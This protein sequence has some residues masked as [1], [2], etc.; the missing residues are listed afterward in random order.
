M[1]NLLEFAVGE[2][3]CYI[4][5]RIHDKDVKHVRCEIT[6]EMAKAM[7]TVVGK[8]IGNKDYICISV[9][10]DASYEKKRVFVYQHDFTY[11]LY[12]VWKD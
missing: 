2:R 4:S 10:E 12:I 5:D 9:N 7:A 1:K 3:H 8:D 6:K 11:Y